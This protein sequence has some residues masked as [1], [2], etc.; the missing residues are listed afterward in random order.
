MGTCF[1]KKF[2]KAL[3][4]YCAKDGFVRRSKQ[5][6][7]HFK[8]TCREEFLA[9][10]GNDVLEHCFYVQEEASI[11]INIPQLELLEGEE[12]LGYGWNRQTL[13]PKCK[14]REPLYFDIIFPCQFVYRPTVDCSSI[15]FFMEGIVKRNKCLKQLWD[16]RIA[17]TRGADGPAPEPALAVQRA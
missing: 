3:L 7:L 9:A 8:D 5:P 13:L 14:G 2:R 15:H 17:F 6:V 11:H 10:F 12:Y 4:E 1:W 16:S